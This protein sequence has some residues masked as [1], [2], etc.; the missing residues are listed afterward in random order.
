[1][2]F[3]DLTIK[4]LR[5]ETSPTDKLFDLWASHNH[6]V[7]ELFILLFHMKHHQSMIPLKDFIDPK[8][9]G[10]LEN[11]KKYQKRTSADRQAGGR[12]TKDLG[13]G[14]LNFNQVQ[15]ASTNVPKVQIQ[16]QANHQQGAKI[17][18]RPPHQDT[19]LP[20]SNSNNMLVRTDP[21]QNHRLV[22]DASKNNNL[23]NPSVIDT[24][25]PQISYEELAKATNNWSKHTILGKGGFGTVFRGW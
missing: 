11:A 14:T 2:K 4:N 24:A 20:P 19:D 17:L 10:L 1:M 9:L 16:G 12:D 3:D 6:T 13:I 25:L 7:L 23:L 15:P 8:Y 22:Q 18:N 5:R 21:N